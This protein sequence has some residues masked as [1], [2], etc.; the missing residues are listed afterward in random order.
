MRKVRRYASFS[1]RQVEFTHTMRKIQLCTL[2]R[3]VDV[4]YSYNKIVIFIIGRS[5]HFTPGGTKVYTLH[6]SKVEWLFTPGR[7][8]VPLNAGGSKVAFYTRREYSRTLR[9]HTLYDTA[10]AATAAKYFYSIYIYIYS[11]KRYTCHAD[12]SRPSAPPSPHR[13]PI[14]PSSK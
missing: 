4:L 12:P 6:P 14:R 1:V 5:V 13:P 10:A 11:S 3:Y 8:K 7:S 9:P 2:K